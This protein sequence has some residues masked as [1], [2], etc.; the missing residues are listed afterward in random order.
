MGGNRRYAHI[1]DELGRRRIEEIALKP[2]PISLTPEE[3]DVEHH[4]VRKAE[5]PIPVHGWVRYP[6][7]VVDVR[8]EAF[9]WNDLGVHLRWHAPDGSQRFAWVWASAVRRIRPPAPGE[10][11]D[12]R[13][14]DLDSYQSHR[15]S[16]DSD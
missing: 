14:R 8:T 2:T 16:P 15:K 10:K 3:L 12:I 7:L 9:E 11:V 13:D 1:Y 5:E 6:E 4:P